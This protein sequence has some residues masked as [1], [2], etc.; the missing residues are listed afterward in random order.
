MAISNWDVLA[1]DQDGTPVPDASLTTI[2]GVTF[3]LY[4]NWVRITSGRMHHPGCGFSAPVIAQLHEGQLQMG[5]A[6]VSATRGPREAIYVVVREPL[7]DAKDEWRERALVGCALLGDVGD[8]WVG[9]G[10]DEVARLASFAAASFPELAGLDL[11]RAVRHN[12]GDRVFAGAYG[13]PAPTSAPGVAGT[14]LL[15]DALRGI[16]ASGGED[17]QRG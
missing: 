1:V 8:T 13:V 6:F 7:R 16:A 2:A 12:Q 17:P 3:E 10:P 11:S 4:K 15:D 14:P 5:G 9:I